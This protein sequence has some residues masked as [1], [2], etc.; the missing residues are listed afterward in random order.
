LPLAVV[1]VSPQ[2]YEDLEQ[3]ALMAVRRALQCFDPSRASLRT[4]VE[5]VVAARLA[6]LMR[7]RGRLPYLSQLKNTI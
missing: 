2:D 4:F 7:A 1:I 5:C 3:E 6:S